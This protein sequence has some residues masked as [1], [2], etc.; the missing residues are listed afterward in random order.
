[1]TALD[2]GFFTAMPFKPKWLRDILGMVFTAY[3]LA[4]ADAADEKV[5]RIRATISVEQMR[6]SWEKGE[7]NFILKAIRRATKPKMKLEDTMWLERSNDKPPTEIYRYFVNSPSDYPDCDTILLDIP[8]G[9]FVSM[10]PACHEEALSEWSKHTGPW[11]IEECFEVYANIIRTKGQCIGLSGTK[12]IKIILDCNLRRLSSGGN[13][14]CGVTSLAITNQLPKPIGLILIYPC[15]DFELSCWMSPN[16]LALIRAESRTELFRSK[17]F[18]SILHTKDHLNHISPLSVV[19][20]RKEKSKGVWQRLTGRSKETPATDT[21][22]DAWA[23]SHVAMT[24]R[25]TFFNDRIVSTDLMRA[26]AIMYLGPHASPDF[27]KDYLLCPI[28]TPEEILAQFPVTFMMCG[29]RDPFVDDTVILAGRIRQARLRYRQNN[30]T[31]SEYL[32]GDGV[33]VKFLEGM[34]HAFLQMLAFLPAAKPTIR[35]LGDWMIE[36]QRNHEASPGKALGDHHVAEIITSETDML[37][38]RKKMLI[39]GLY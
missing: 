24:S 21:E 36:I 35:T 7:R 30:P 26:M 20:D 9:G 18:S 1:M 25:V 17:S 28:H 34:S 22:D 2:A 15:L 39:D 3:Y 33:R 31:D 27:S 19:P 13:I 16:Q 38:R 10:G 37:H 29:E 4:F 32:Q 12:D 23:S 14:S 5:K 6:Y 11:A 8:G